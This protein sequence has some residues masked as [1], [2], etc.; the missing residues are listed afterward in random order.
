MEKTGFLSTFFF[1][2]QNLKRGYTRLFGRA[3]SRIFFFYAFLKISPQKSNT[4]EKTKMKPAELTNFYNMNK[5]KL[6][7]SNL[8]LRALVVSFKKSLIRRTSLKSNLK[9]R[10]TSI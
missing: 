3:K 7:Q 2:I 4:L 6:L 10:S 5:K 1:Q 9:H 8:N